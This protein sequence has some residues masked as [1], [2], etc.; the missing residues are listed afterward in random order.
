[1]PLRISVCFLWFSLLFLSN[2]VGLSAGEEDRRIVVLTGANLIDGAGHSPVQNAVLTIQ[3][4]KVS[5]VG[6]FGSVDYPAD[7][8]VIDCRGQTIIPGLISDHATRQT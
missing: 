3:G 4:D 2:A 5:A 8:E 7:A 6:P 1:M